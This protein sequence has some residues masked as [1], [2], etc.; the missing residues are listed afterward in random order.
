MVKHYNSNSDL[1][2]FFRKISF[3]KQYIQALKKNLFFLSHVKEYNYKSLNS[4]LVQKPLSCT[5]KLVSYIINISFSRTNTLL[6]LM[7]PSGKLMFFYS[8][9]NFSYKGKNKKARILVFNSML[10]FISKNFKFLYYKPV[11][12]HLKN[13]KFMKRRFIKKLTKKFPLLLVKNF[14]VYPHNGC[15]IKKIRRKKFKKLIKNKL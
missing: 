15:R 14:N 1:N 11:V 9:G 2:K 5:E 6:H 7:D 4:F 3:K 12:L 10:K 13:V 8:A